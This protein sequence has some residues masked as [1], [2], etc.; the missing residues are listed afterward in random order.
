MTPPELVAQACPIIGVAGNAFYFTSESLAA[1]A[2]LGLDRL[3]WYVGGRGGVLGNVESSVVRAAFGYFNPTMIDRGWLGATAV[4]PPRTIG[5]VFYECSAAHG[6]RTL[7]DV[8]G[9]DRFVAAADAVLAAADATGLSMF[10]A[11]AA[12]PMVDDVPGRAM[13]LLTVLREYRG[14]AHLVALRASGIDSKTAHFVKRPN[15]LKLFGWT[16][17]DA[18][19]ITDETHTAMTRAEA[20]TDAIVAPAF[21]V[22]GDETAT[23]FVDTLG[24]IQTVLAG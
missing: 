22:L 6:R 4:C 11:L 16:E 8:D 18:P 12:E 2:E 10:A 17:S 3:Q 23:M 1:G 21:G 9:L 15:D 5:R 13:Q 7:A 20:L 14:S 24:A 19:V